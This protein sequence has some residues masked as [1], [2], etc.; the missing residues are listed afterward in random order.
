MGSERALLD[1]AGLPGR[2]WFRHLVY[3]P[4]PSYEAETLPGAREALAEGNGARAAAEARRL[5]ARL[6]VSPSY[7]RN[8]GE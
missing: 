3:A 5:A 6:S 8:G 7:A 2:P 1:P 4:L